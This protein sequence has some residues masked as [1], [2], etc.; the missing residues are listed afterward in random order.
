MIERGKI[1]EVRVKSLGELD[2]LDERS[3]V[4]N[5]LIEMR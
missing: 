2:E 5:K 1:Q 3:F 4:I